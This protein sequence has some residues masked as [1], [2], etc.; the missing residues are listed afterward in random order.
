MKKTNPTWLKLGH[1]E[2]ENTGNNESTGE[3]NKTA[4]IS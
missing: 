4:S 1:E 3:S 2:I